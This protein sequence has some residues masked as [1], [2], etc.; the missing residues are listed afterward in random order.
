MSKVYF[1]KVSATTTVED[2]QGIS[3]ELLIIILKKEKIVL[4]KEVPLKV[5]FGERGN[6][7]FIKPENFQG[8]IDLLKEKNIKSSFMETN[9]I[10]GGQRHKS[11]IHEVLAKEHGFTQ[12]PVVIADGKSGEEYEEV[13]INKK[14][15]KT[16]K[17]GKAFIPHKQMIVISHFKGHRLAGFGGAIKQLAM[18]FGT[19]GGKLAMHMG[20]KP[21]IR[22]RKC[23]ACNACVPR[24]N[25]NALHIHKKKKSYIDH[26]VC[27]GCG[28]CVPACPH[29]AISFFSVRGIRNAITQGGAF[30]EKM[31]EYAFAAQKDKEF[32]YLT[33]AMDI[34]KGCDCE[35]RSMKPF[36]P[37][38]GV[39]VSTD[40]VALDRACVDMAK[41][42]GKKFKGTSIFAYAKSIGLGSSSYDL[43]EL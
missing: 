41:T 13:E 12:L 28:A 2:V 16:A 43:I 7:T 31:A 40:P 19:K 23:V 6:K 38:L 20:V 32:I 30:K 3:K 9:T 4:G 25:V 34:T 18:G 14:H 26:E 22:N 5:H 37:D 24:C 10:Y 15:F 11:D 17:I 33:F 42:L 27:V 35:P 29:K 1:K 36:M 39:F 8:V 21:R